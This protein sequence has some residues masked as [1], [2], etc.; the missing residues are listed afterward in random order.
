MTGRAAPDGIGFARVLGGEV[1]TTGGRAVACAAT[2]LTE[3]ARARARTAE[4]RKI[5]GRHEV[6]C[7]NIT[8]QDFP[9]GARASGS[10]ADTAGLRI[11]D[12]R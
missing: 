1:T 8:F 5:I 9:R 3:D 12:G 10:P 11:R 7:Y 2:S 4:T 6:R